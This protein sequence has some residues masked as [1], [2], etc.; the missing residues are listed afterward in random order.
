MT[1]LNDNERALL[2]AMCESGADVISFTEDKQS[3]DGKGIEECTWYLDNG[4][5]NHMTGCIEQ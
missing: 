5:S 2:M 3:K 4:A 1:Q